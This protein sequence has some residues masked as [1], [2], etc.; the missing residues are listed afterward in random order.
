MLQASDG[1][2]VRARSIRL[3]S[4]IDGTG[5]LI[6]GAPVGLPPVAPGTLDVSTVDFSSNMGTLVFNH[7]QN[8]YAFIPELRGGGVIQQEAGSTNLVL[9]QSSFTGSTNINGG[10]LVVQNS[11]GGRVTVGSSGSLTASGRLGD[12]AVGFNGILEPGGF[13]EP[14]TLTIGSLTLN[15]GALMRFD[16][17]Q[18]GIAG[19]AS[20]LIVVENDLV[21]DG[22]A[23]LVGSANFGNGVYTLFDYGNLAVDNGLEVIDGPAG[24]R[25][26]VGAGPVNS[27]AGVVTVLVST[28][29][30]GGNLFWDGAG[31]ANNGI[32]EGG[33]GVWNA[34]NTNWTNMAGDAN[35]IWNDDFAIF[36]GTA[37]TVTVEGSRRLSG[38]QFRTDGYEI[39]AGASGNLAFRNVAGGADI[40]TDAGVTAVI[41]A[42]ISP[43]ANIN[44]R[45]AGTLLFTGASTTGNPASFA[46]IFNVAQGVLQIA[47]GGVLQRADVRVGS[48][49]GTTGTVEIAGSG[50]LINASSVNVGDLDGDGTLRVVNDGRLQAVNFSVGGR[51]GIG[52][53]TLDNATAS[54]GFGSISSG[55]LDIV[56]GSAFEARNNFF[57]NS[58]EAGT[59]ATA[60][61]SGAGSRFQ[62]NANL[63]IG[64]N[65]SNGFSTFGVA[66]G[67]TVAASQINLGAGATS[68]GFLTIGGLDAPAAA[69]FVETPSIVFG[70]GSG[71]LALNHTSVNYTFAP[72]LSSSVEG[73]GFLNVGAGTTTL[74]ADNSGFTGQTTIFGGR[75]NVDSRLGGNVLV[76]HGGALGGGGSLG[77]V[78]LTEGAVSPGNSA[79]TLTLANLSIG[80]SGVLDFELGAPGVVGSGFNDLIVVTGGLRL[81]GTL[82]VSAL[83][84]FGDGLYTLIQYGELLA[85][86]GLDLGTT[87]TGFTYN[88]G[89]GTG[90]KS[91]VTLEVASGSASSLQY[92]DGFDSAADGTV[93]G[94]SG[95]WEA[96]RTNWT[97]QDGSENAAWGGNFAIFS[98]APG[99]VT[100]LGP[101]TFTGMQFLTDGYR[102]GTGTDDAALVTNTSQTNI[103]VGA[104]INATIQAPIM[105]TGRLVK[106]E[107][108]TLTV[109][110]DGSSR[111]RVAGGELVVAGYMASPQ[112]VG[113]AVQTPLF[114]LD[115]G[116]T[117]TLADTGSITVASSYQGRAIEALAGGATINIDGIVT[118]G[119]A[120]AM[121]LGP[122][123]TATPN[124][125]VVP[126]T[127]F[128]TVA[129]AVYADAASDILTDYLADPAGF[130]SAQ[131]EILLPDL[132]DGVESPQLTAVTITGGVSGTIALNGGASLALDVDGGLLGTAANGAPAVEMRDQNTVVEAVVRNGG[133]IATT[134]ANA[135]GI[136]GTGNSATLIGIEGG[137]S[138]STAGNGSAAIDLLAD[139]MISFF[140]STGGGATPIIET[141]GDNAPGYRA[142]GVGSS[143]ITFQ[144]EGPD[145]RLVTRGDNSDLLLID[146]V[147]N[148]SASFVVQ[149]ASLTTQGAGSG[150]AT[151]VT[152]NGSDTTLIFQDVI[153]RTEGNDAGALNFSQRGG[154]S[155]IVKILTRNDIATLGNGSAGIS[156]D[157]DTYLSSVGFMNFVDT[158]IST[159]GADSD[160]MRLTFGTFDRSAGDFI[161]DGLTV[162]TAGERSRGVALAFAPQNDAMLDVNLTDVAV[163]TSGALAHGV[164]IDGLGSP[165]ADTSNELTMTNVSATVSGAGAHAFVIGPNTRITDAPSRL[166]PAAPGG[167]GGLIDSFDGFV[168]TGEG[169]RAIYNLGLIDGGADGIVLGTGVRGNIANGGTITAQGPNAVTFGAS[170]D[171]FELLPGGVVVGNVLAGEGTDTFI[172]GGEGT[173]SF[174][175]SLIDGDGIDNGEQY[176][177]FETFQKAGGSTW[178]LTGVNPL[179]DNFTVLGG[180]AINNGALPFAATTVVAGATLGGSG[181]LGALTV[182]SGATVAPGNSVGTLTVNGDAT[183]EAGSTYAVEVDAAGNADLLAVSGVAFLDGTIAVDALGYPTGYATANNYTVLTAGGGVSGRFDNVTD[184]LPDIDAVVTYNPNDV[185]IGLGQTVDPLDVSP[186]EVYPNA[187]QASL[188]SA[189]LFAG[190]MRDR[191]RIGASRASAS[192]TGL[193]SSFAPV[194]G[195]EAEAVAG[196]PYG[197]ASW[198]GIAGQAIDRRPVG[199]VPGYDTELWSV[200]SGFD[201]TF[202]LGTGVARAGIALGYSST[203]IDVGLSSARMQGWNAG[204]YGS[205]EDGPLAL[206][207][208]LGHGVLD[209]DFSRPIQLG[210]G[211]FVTASGSASGNVSVAAARASFDVAGH[212]GLL[213]GIGLRLAPTASVEHLWARRGGFTETGVG[214]LALTLG[215]DSINQ[216][217][218]GI[219][220]ETSARFLTEAGIVLTPSLS[221]MYEHNA[222]DRRAV[223]ASAVPGAAATFSTPGVLEDA[224]LVSIG[225]GFGVEFNDK[226]TLSLGYTGE[227]GSNSTS[228]TGQVSFSVRF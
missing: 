97:T 76:R 157:A 116:T 188:A 125:D 42:P 13:Q 41:D 165:D 178:T 131:R 167:I 95:F 33:S 156:F 24:Y 222:G 186:K 202:D 52:A 88:L 195:G 121:L 115:A 86:N 65:N 103:R 225:A 219:G 208:A 80:S 2:S 144:V 94:G 203:G 48:G 62:G 215:S 113:D 206:S 58:R 106:Q 200:A 199:G 148:N 107:G 114:S 61:V 179:I 134:G 7:T 191:A 141:S 77:N 161:F 118:A 133:R 226:A 198:A 164:V 59:R 123:N 102:I 110:R 12:V 22:L 158:S 105:E 37:G 98:G 87:P 124:P 78:S 69:G 36:G 204:L 19:R 130:D 44:K 189:D 154:D 6:I 4:G 38:M 122:S 227:F 28:A 5:T 216:T 101:Q 223:S 220:V 29:P 210:G 67:G 91:A 9:D 85:D 135:P 136:F 15:A 57:V 117:L 205:Y 68:S 55:T 176:R 213:S 72:Q 49:A 201:A 177:G 160:G 138:I 17:D 35:D 30:A 196:A 211:G 173:A 170:N 147:D 21:L 187:L 224:G 139:S 214:P 128:V 56:G 190:L 180:L 8:G 207:G 89:S 81:D 132:G 112:P 228:H 197:I 71:T 162:T 90:T 70:A 109:T 25:F 60:T 45:G 31:P 169:G 23:T 185:V 99:L 193:V 26:E 181:E 182:Q 143:V 83:P 218:L 64:G 172:L 74:T 92:W 34:S 46:G 84:D 3:A 166:A 171:I 140:Q 20:D 39:V 149:G 27:G 174:D 111:W 209:A 151:I 108:G 32:V 11:L 82:N 120:E 96:A 14:T 50:S 221:V 54:V 155:T 175:V 150:A 145:A 104:G 18:A 119:G 16:L 217:W 43:D 159:Q 183:F 146:M 184:T 73:A 126:A 10:T 66:D 129:K 100:V 93:D 47:D 1:G 40:L 142:A 127:Q 212:L 63:T 168:A 75:L 53:V 192:S 194:E 79:G 51:G 137:S 163:T 153:T 152:G